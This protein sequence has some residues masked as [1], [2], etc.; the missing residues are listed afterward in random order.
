M[1]QIRGRSN[2]C[3]PGY[4]QA[5]EAG[6]SVARTWTWEGTVQ[7]LRII[8]LVVLV[9]VCGRPRPTAWTVTEQILCRSEARPAADHRRF[10][11]ALGALA[12][13]KIFRLPK[14]P[15]LIDTYYILPLRACHSPPLI[16]HNTLKHRR[17][18]D[19]LPTGPTGALPFVV[20]RVQDVNIHR[21]KLFLD[22]PYI[23]ASAWF[24]R[25]PSVMKRD[26][27]AFA[28]GWSEDVTHQQRPLPMQDQGCRFAELVAC[29]RLLLV[30]SGHQGVAAAIVCATGFRAFWVPAFFSFLIPHQAKYSH[31]SFSQS[32]CCV[33][34][35]TCTG[36]ISLA[37]PDLYYPII[38]LH[39][40]ATGKRG[41]LVVSASRPRPL[42]EVSLLCW[43]L[44]AEET[45][46]RKSL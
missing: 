27:P 24:R 19:R 46:E 43:L 14:L 11:T 8:V 31:Q 32:N 40:F 28:D 33:P 29:Q 6:L 7:S 45:D 25:G 41:R 18:G 3:E 13:R 35:R 23:S 22:G 38:W 4:A 12:E 17:E 30:A 37:R 21:R 15:D 10:G 20:S 26:P 16:N 9:P 39:D 36:L 5:L 44:N 1:L 42:W 2:F 34:Q